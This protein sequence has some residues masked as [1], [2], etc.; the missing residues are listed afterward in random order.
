MQRTSERR[1]RRARPVQMMGSMYLSS[2][3][4]E[5][6]T[7]VNLSSSLLLAL[8]FFLL[9]FPLILSALWL[10]QIVTV[11]T[12]NQTILNWKKGETI[13]HPSPS[14]VMSAVSVNMSLVAVAWVNLV[15]CLLPKG[16]AVCLVCVCVCVLS[17]VT[18]LCFLLLLLALLILSN[19]FFS[20]KIS[21]L[22]LYLTWACFDSCSHSFKTCKC[23]SLLLGKVGIL[24]RGAICQHSSLERLLAKL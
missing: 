12:C 14:S 6:F 23:F 24:W 4:S 18:L 13:S 1:T 15:F 7:C 10:E 16:Y 21:E 8:F 19:P 22:S 11:V 9:C 17:F 2:L 20:I 3:S 5:L